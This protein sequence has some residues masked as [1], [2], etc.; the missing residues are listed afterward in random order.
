MSDVFTC[1]VQVRWGDSDRLG[2][3]NNT[4]YAEYMQEARIQFLTSKLAAHGGRPGYVVVRKMSIEFLKPVTD[5]S[6]PLNVEIFTTHVGTS[7]FTVR[8]VVRDNTGAECA[9]GDALMV[10]FDTVS[11]KSRPLADSERLVLEAALVPA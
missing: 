1:E 4:R 9:S 5:R 10:G 8:H 6:G 3:V 7:S 11:E 2:H